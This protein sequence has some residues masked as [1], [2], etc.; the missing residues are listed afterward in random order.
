MNELSFLILALSVL[1]LA[2][3]LVKVNEK[4]DQTIKTV[5]KFEKLFNLIKKRK[6]S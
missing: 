3:A 6:S 1:V 5:R 4:L 2:W